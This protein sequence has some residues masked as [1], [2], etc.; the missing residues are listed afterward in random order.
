MSLLFARA[1]Q[2]LRPHPS[3][4][5]S[6][7][8]LAG[9]PPGVRPTTTWLQ[10]LDAGTI[11]PK[12]VQSEFFSLALPA[13]RR[14]HGRDSEIYPCGTSSM[15]VLRFFLTHPSVAELG[16]ARARPCTRVS[17]SGRRPLSR[18]RPDTLPRSCIT[19]HDLDRGPS[20]SAHRPATPQTAVQI[21]Q[22]TASAA[23]TSGFLASYSYSPHRKRLGGSRFSRLRSVCRGVS[24]Q[25][26]ADYTGVSACLFRDFTSNLTFHSGMLRSSC[27][28]SKI[29]EEIWEVSRN[30]TDRFRSAVKL[31]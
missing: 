9:V 8:W 3:L 29:L 26:L 10:P 7:Q 12:Q 6:R 1:T 19:R 23:N 30:G 27:G 5:L 15:H 18:P 25:G 20:L 17:I 31:T 16:C 22:L 13:L 24:D 14:N 28:I 11:P 2:R 21:P 4:R